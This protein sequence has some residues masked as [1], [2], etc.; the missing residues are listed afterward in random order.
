MRWRNGVLLVA[1]VAFYAWG[2]GAGVALVAAS[3]VANWFFG[4]RIGRS[5]SPSDRKRWVALAIAANLAL[6]AA[7]KYSAFAVATFGSF[8]P[9]P[10][11]LRAFA[12]AIVLPLGIS[13]FTFHAISYVVDVYRGRASHEGNLGTFAL[14]I[15]LFPQLI[16]GPIIRWRDIAGQ[17]RGRSVDV[18]DMAEG[19][20][21]F[22]WGLGK[23]V[24]IA[25]PLGHV[26]DQV[27]ALP[28]D[29]LST[30]S[31]WL[32]LACY[33]LQIYFDFS[34]YSDM[35]IGLMRMFGFRILENFDYPYIARSVREFWQRWHISLSNWFR[36][37][38]YVP[39]GGNRLGPARTYL[40]LLIV[41]LLCGL[42]HG[43]A[44]TFIAWGAWHG[45]FLMFERAG[46]QHLLAR[47]GPL[48]HAYALGAVMG[49]WVLFRS[50]DL[51]QAASFYS[52][53]VGRGVTG[54]DVTTATRFLDPYVLTVLVAG[55]IGSMPVAR[56]V[57]GIAR[58]AALRPGLAGT[59]A[60]GLMVSMTLGVFVVAASWLAA[61][62]YNPFIYFRF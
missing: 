14:Y 7:F 31:A 23:K 42:W 10:G 43:A 9:M 48:R 3:V 36:D 34:G 32:G 22:A 24:L 12:N 39:L 52:A 13:F 41:F 45:V 60:Q 49:G 37:Y 18:A 56:R 55:I 21:R 17:L 2:E 27:F 38:V 40:N 15:G 5:S 29:Q 6:L 1:S 61:G 59:A 58:E 19:V 44:W 62:S 4:L 16:A 51:S 28:A 57:G 35:A 50:A 33:T 46:G 8:L 54:P 47:L 11:T 25:N 30:S 53:L 20:R 26:A